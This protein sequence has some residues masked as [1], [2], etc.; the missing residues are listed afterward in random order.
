[1]KHSGSFSYLIAAIA[2]VAIMALRIYCSQINIFTKAERDCDQGRAILLNEATH[3]QHL[4]SL[5]ILRGYL[6]NED[7]ALF[8]AHRIIDEIRNNGG[9]PKSI[10]EL[11]DKRFGLD[12]DSTG[13]SNISSFPYL[14]SRAEEL[15]GGRSESR[16][17]YLIA[18]VGSAKKFSVIIRNNDG[19]IHQD[20]VYLQV[21]EHFNEI[22][23]DGGKIIDCHSR[24]SLYA[25]VPVC[26]K[27]NIW[28]PIKDPQN[29]SE[30]HF[31]I[32]PVERGFEF[33]NAKGTYKNTSHIFKFSRKPAVL[34]LIGSKMLKQMREDS[35]LIIR[36]PKEYRDKFISSFVIFAGLW[37]M[38]FLTLSIIDKKREGKSNLKLLAIVVLLSGLGLANL[39]AIQ[40]PL[41]GELYGWSQLLKGLILGMFLLVLFAYVDWVALYQY[42]HKAHLSS[43]KQRSQGLWMA[44][45]AI[46]IAIILLLFGH[47]P[48]GT[49]ITLPILQIQGSPVIK[50][51]I[52]GYLAIFFVTRGDL[53][54]AYTRPGAIGK[55]MVILLSSILCLFALGL[56]QLMISDLGPFLVIAI[57]AIFIFSLVTKETISMLIGSGIFG[58]LLLLGNRFIH[59]DFLPFAIFIPYT[60]IMAL[61]SYNK[62]GRVKISPIALGFIILMAFHGGPLLSSL[63]MNNLAERLNGRAEIAARVFDNEVVGGSQVCE[64]IW[65]IS[66]GGFWGA[67]GS[68]LSATLPAGHTDLVFESFI[69]NT[70]VL[71][72]L[73]VLLGI[74]LIIIFSLKIGIRNGHPFGFALASLTALS[75]GVQASLIIL[76][77]LGLIPLTGVTVP[78]L[79]FGGTSIALD[80]ASIGILISLSRHEDHEWENIN[81]KKYER[82]SQGQAWAYIVLASIAMLMIFNYG[83]FSRKNYLIKPG[84]FINNTGERIVLENP[85]I[86]VVE[87]QLIPGKILDRRGNVVAETDESGVRIYKYGSHTLFMLGDTETKI[88]SGTTGKRSSCIAAE[89]RYKPQILGYETHPINLPVPSTKHYSRFLPSVHMEKESTVR[90][91][92]YSS[93]LPMMLS[94]RRISKWNEQKA[95]RNIQLTFDAELQVELDEK[96]ASFIQ[97]MKLSGKTTNRTRGSVTI[98]DAFD[99]SLLASAMYPLGDPSILKELALTNTTIYR[100]WMPNFKAYSDMDL[101]LVPLAPGSCAKIITAG[102][103]LKRFSTSLAG[104]DFYQ[105]VHAAEIIDTTLGEPIGYVSL[106]QAIVLS[107][108]VYFIK[109]LNRYG[110][111]G[112][113]PELSEIYYAIGANF[114][115]STPY[116]LYPEQVITSEPSYRKQ[117]ESFG[118][119][120]ARN[121]SLYEASGIRHRLNNAEYQPAWGQNVTMTPLSLC[122][123]VAAIA[124][125]G[126]MMAPRYNTSDSVSVHKQI[127][128]KEE[129]RILQDCMK[130]Q[131]A[132]RFGSHIG[133]KTGTP[134]RT[135]RTKATGQSNDALYCFFVDAAG[136]PS[137]HPLAVVIRLERVNDYSRIAMQMA[138]DVVLPVL[139]EKGYIIKD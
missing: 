58:A 32:I 85:L 104:K 41:R 109:L 18:K 53:L 34:P 36:S 38:V 135:D 35:S 75:I 131:S 133:G 62:H 86:D 90:V 46:F 56:L 20:T 103:G 71:G 67:P 21:K 39:F 29:G 43:G 111:K 81:T 87:K 138:N 79:S 126:K 40:H 91:E 52:T 127:M 93:L 27:S 139:R 100:D 99:G 137:E 15:A 130:A 117:M 94:Q 61:C 74:G 47:G 25:W 37:I 31:S 122:R 113:Y 13:F 64:G 33:G 69:E 16:G 65:A 118:E 24:D 50:L 77:S 83:C 82:M 88:L 128:N 45:S 22:V 95:G 9:R 6:N 120:A 98:L 10:R 114:G 12:L 124:N 5:M 96:I 51:L 136:T 54:E 60:A 57:T 73:V 14:S 1:M 70:G 132:G 2:V 4:A 72:G 17:K 102:A 76:G 8:I 23:K 116:V 48:G 55:Q 80:L 3:P 101:M 119:I 134:S 30:R 105:F 28:L 97:S 84:K 59:L 42:S 19:T 68:G 108:N 7:E 63:G 121:Y 26:G 11:G 123:Y 112:L 92:D 110:P 66:R 44:L 107:S 106:K 129:A 89:E 115:L 125:D 49:H 78:Y